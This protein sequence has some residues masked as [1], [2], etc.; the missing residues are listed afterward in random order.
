MSRSDETSGLNGNVRSLTT[1][2]LAG[3]LVFS[4]RSI[5]NRHR[6]QMEC[7]R[8]SLRMTR[9]VVKILGVDPTWTE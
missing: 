8:E 7:A 2:L 5:P 9:C 3:M 4:L 6:R 1:V